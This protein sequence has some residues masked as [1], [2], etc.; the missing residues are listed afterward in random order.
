[1]RRL[2]TALA[3]L[4]LSAL[5]LTACG[6]G[7]SSGSSSGS[8]GSNLPV[9]KIAITFTGSD[10]TPNG[11]DIDVK[12]GQPLEFDVTADKPGEIHVHS[13]PQEQEFEYKA[14]SSKFQVKPVPA[15]T[16]VVVESHTLDK[17]LFTLVAR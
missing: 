9:K 3:V 13:S 1:M 8:S 11:T 6:G 7:S 16:Q 10:V 17:T 15:P 14:G 12:V 5:T 4:L 2:V